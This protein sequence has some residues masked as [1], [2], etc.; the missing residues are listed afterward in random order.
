MLQ[1]KIA[2]ITGASGVIGRAATAVFQREGATV[3]GIDVKD[4]GTECEHFVQADLTVAE[5]VRETFAD[6]QGR[7]GGLDALFS[8]AGVALENDGSVVSTPTSVWDDTLRINVRSMFLVNKHGVELM[9][10]NGGGSIVNTASLLGS[11]GSADQGVAY[12]ASKGAVLALTRETAVGYAK[13]GIR[14]N[15]VSPGP[16]ET[17]LF[18]DL[19]DDAGRSRRLVHAPTGR[20]TY[21][22]EIAEVVAF[23][24]SDRASH[25]N[26]INVNVDGGMSVA[27]VTP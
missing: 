3:V 2:V 21:A 5:Q 13:R 15:S 10:R 9:L 6:V 1:G 20:F 16:V 23:L 4:S 17:P 12:A 11:V 7:F 19:V 8:N 22:E 14:V 26:G 24:V 18:T 27:Y 25:V